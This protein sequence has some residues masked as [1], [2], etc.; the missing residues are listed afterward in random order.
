MQYPKIGIRP[1]IDG[2]WGGF[3]ESLEQSTMD[4]ARA[5][6]ELISTLK[7]PDGTPVQCVISDTTI[8]GGA[9]AG[10]GKRFSAKRKLVA[11]QRLMRGESLETLSR[12]LNVP[13]HRLSEWRDRVLFAAETAL[14]ENRRPP[15]TTFATRLILISFSVSPSLFSL[16]L[17]LS[18]LSRFLSTLSP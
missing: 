2:R 10:R 8:G 9:E 11:V 13:A 7:Y 3:R 14:K 4:M 17:S 18:L 12:E 1:V 6:A 15:F 5:A 16:S